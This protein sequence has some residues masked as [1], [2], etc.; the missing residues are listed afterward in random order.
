M[1]PT[2]SAITSGDV[3]MLATTESED[4]DEDEDEVWN[5][6]LIFMNEHMNVLKSAQGK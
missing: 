3:G 2:F 4:E 6:S 1:E 5:R